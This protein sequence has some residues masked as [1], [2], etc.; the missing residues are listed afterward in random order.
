MFPRPRNPSPARYKSQVLVAMSDPRREHP[1]RKYHDL[2]LFA[3]ACFIVCI[4]QQYI[5]NKLYVYIRS[6]WNAATMTLGCLTGRLE[7]SDLSEEALLHSTPL[8]SPA[9]LEANLVRAHASRRWF[10][11]RTRRQYAYLPICYCCLL[12]SI[13]LRES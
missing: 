8:L 7:K 11:I 10:P 13:R 12:W 1:S 2:F 6:K 3:K 5:Y 9:T 4:L